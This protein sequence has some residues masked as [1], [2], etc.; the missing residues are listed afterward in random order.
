[1]RT[2]FICGSTMRIGRL[3]KITWLTW[4]HRESGN[5]TKITKFKGIRTDRSSNLTMITQI[6]KEVEAQR[7]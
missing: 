5:F 6:R 2:Q 4:K 3:P 7:G 1:M